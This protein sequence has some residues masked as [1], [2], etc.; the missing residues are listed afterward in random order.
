MSDYFLGEIRMFGFNFAPQDWAMCQ[1]QPMPIQQNAA[2]YS[3][4]G[5]RYGGD[6]RT[7]F[8]LPDLRGRVPVSQGMAASGTLYEIGE[9]AGMEAVSLTAAQA[10]PHTHDLQVVGATGTTAAPSDLYFAG[11]VNDASGN[12]H[13]IYATANG[14]GAP[15][16]VN[17]GT[18]SAAGGGPH[19]NMQPFSVLNFC[20][21]VAGIYPP[22]Q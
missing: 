22:R 12:S 2:L 16:A 11:V 20:I 10:P 5:I 8:Q 17:S 14:A 19:N 18:V 21:S 7:T 15:V 6:G 4:L 9:Q 3:L 1:G 13:P